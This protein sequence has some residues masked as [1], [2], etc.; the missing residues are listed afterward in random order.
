MK[1]PL[2]DE[3]GGENWVEVPD[4]VMTAAIL[5][6]SWLESRESVGSFCGLC[7]VTTYLTNGTRLVRALKECRNFLEK[8]LPMDGDHEENRRFF[9]R[10]K[11]ALTPYQA[12]KGGAK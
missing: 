12:S 9:E 7:L 5:V 10:V 4:E 1:I 11:K 3:N 6:R 2:F 8:E